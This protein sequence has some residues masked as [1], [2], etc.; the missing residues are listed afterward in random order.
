VL[1]AEDLVHAAQE[2]NGLKVLAAAIDVRQP[3]PVF[4]AIVAVE[5]RGDGIHAQAVD[6]VAFDPEQRVADQVVAD[7]TAAEVVD[8]GAPVLM[9]ALARVGMLV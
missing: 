3:L 8:Q 7:F 6:A 5:H 4:A 1:L 9:H 2:G